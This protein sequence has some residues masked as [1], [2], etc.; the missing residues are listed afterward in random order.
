MADNW[1]VVNQRQTTREVNG[2]FQ[3]VKEVTFQTTSGYTGSVYV[4]T[5]TYSAETV[6][7]AIDAEVTEVERV[8][9]L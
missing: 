2:K 7:A 3:P 4:P 9:Q 8:N 5:A 1:R 6:K